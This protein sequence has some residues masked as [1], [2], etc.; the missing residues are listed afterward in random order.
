MKFKFTNQAKTRATAFTDK[1]P[2]GP[3]SQTLMVFEKK[4][5]DWSSELKD[6][7]ELA[8][9]KR[10]EI[11]ADFFQWLDNQ[12]TTAPEPEEAPTE[13][14]PA[15][16]DDLRPAVVIP[17]IKPHPVS[18]TTSPEYLEHAAQHFTDAQFIE[19]YADRWHKPTFRTYTEAVAPTFYARASSLFQN[20]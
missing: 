12:T 5:D 4:G 10:E 15:E 7:I 9:G 3:K 20:P 2:T 13:T 18:G 11:E 19:L 17:E 14:P 1:T 8:E 16:P 6:G